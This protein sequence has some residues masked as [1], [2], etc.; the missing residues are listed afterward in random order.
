MQLVGLDFESYWGPG[1]TLRSMTT[2]EYVRDPRFQAI[3]CAIKVGDTPAVWYPRPRIGEALRSVDWDNS[4]MIAHNNIFDSFVAH[5]HYGITPKAYACT[6]SMARGLGLQLY[7]GIGLGACIAWANK[8]G[9][10]LP[11]KDDNAVNEASGMRYED[12]TPDHLA[13]YGKYCRDDTEGTYGL[14]K[15][16]VETLG[17]PA[18]ELRSV[19]EFMRMFSEPRLT[20]DAE[21]LRQRLAA[22]QKR[23]ST[24]LSELGVS[25]KAIRSDNLFAKLLMD[26]GVDPPTKLSPK[27]KNEDGTPKEVWAFSKTDEEF[28]DLQEHENWTVQ[29]LVAARLKLKSTIEES[30]MTRLLG[31]ESRG[32]LPVPLQYYGA[33]TGRCA[34]LGKINLNNLTRAAK[35]KHGDEGMIVKMGDEYHIVDKINNKASGKPPTKFTVEHDF[36]NDGTITDT[37]PPVFLVKDYYLASIRDTIMAPP[38]QILCVGDSS[39]I[40]ARGVAWV[41]GQQDMLDDFARFDVTK[42]NEDVYTTFGCVLYNRHVTKADEDERQI[43]KVCILGLGYQVGWA[44]LRKTIKA[45]AGKEVSEEFARSAVMVYRTKNYAIKEFWKTCTTALHSMVDGQPFAFG[46]NNCLLALPPDAT[47][48][49]ARIRLPNGMYLRYPGLRREQGDKG[50][51]FSYITSKGKSQ[52]YTKIYGGSLT[53]NIVQALARIIVV[54][55]WDNIRRRA[56]KEGIVL[57]SPIVLHVYDELV[58]QVAIE[59]KTDI[60]TIMREEMRRGPAWAVGYP[61]NCS[62]GTSVRYGDAK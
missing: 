7:G 33:H 59:H 35:I 6:M 19:D 17:Y 3:G 29:M 49:M 24:F 18:A 1:Y 32:L 23:K 38:G 21:L 54:W 50:P 12:F 13:R 27:Q 22:Y 28:K 15:F 52:F 34:A 5:E 20:L 26:H 14:F 25:L 43:S 57:T 9:A 56:A 31:I 48:E 2:E 58:S 46:P 45:Q 30:R 40:E 44:K 41:S 11:P 8:H 42:S 4:M 39:Q 16:Y 62:I 55:Q 47:D 36:I 37:D 51:Q 10:N 61:L 53:E 60:E